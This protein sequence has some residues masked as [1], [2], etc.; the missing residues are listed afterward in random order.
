MSGNIHQQKDQV[1]TAIL[2]LGYTKRY[3]K[4]FISN[5]KKHHNSNLPNM[6]YSSK[7]MFKAGEPYHISTYDL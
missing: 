2:S 4:R 5:F 1:S 3:F 7:Y 6:S